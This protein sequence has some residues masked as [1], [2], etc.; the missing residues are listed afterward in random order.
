MK[1][2]LWLFSLIVLTIST[3]K[4]D[5]FSPPTMDR[6]GLLGGAYVALADG[7]EA[8]VWN[9]AGL[10]LP[11]RNYKYELGRPLFSGGPYATIKTVSET[12][13]G[14]GK[15]MGLFPT[16]SSSESTLSI[17]SPSIG[18]ILFKTVGLYLYGYGYRNSLT[19][20]ITPYKGV[21]VWAGSGEVSMGMGFSLSD[22]IF[23]GFSLSY[24]RI[25]WGYSLPL[26]ENLYYND[27][28]LNKNKATNEYYKDPPS[29]GGIRATMGFIY[30]PSDW[31]KIG[32]SMKIPA[33]IS[34]SG[35]AQLYA[36]YEFLEEIGKSYAGDLKF[37]SEVK[38]DFY[39]P[40]WIG[41]GFS[42]S[43]GKLIFSFDLHWTQWSRVKEIKSEF[44]EKTWKEV[45]EPYLEKIKDIPLSWKD[46][47]EICMG[48]KYKIVG[49]RISILLG[50]RFQP[51]QF[52]KGT[53]LPAY[54]PFNDYHIF[55]LGIE[56]ENQKEGYRFSMGFIFYKGKPID[57][58]QSNFGFFQGEYNSSMWMFTGGISSLRLIPY[59]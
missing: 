5:L 2:V 26:K 17:F 51:S 47:T 7:P 36:T 16:F 12:L 58:S 37:E 18:L 31:L 28:F 23:T 24:Q 44:T 38:K 41:G 57:V 56:G 43:K 50:Y 33:K 25:F 4:A 48:I 15:I 22:T 45:L 13:K 21:E 54:F 11:L 39:L 20:K 30:R 40:L 10:A 6:A 53:I 19:P 52:T 42:I 8:V 35:K 49:E 14:K 9:P 34:L 59:F 46:T 55:S 3:L 29:G 32:L 1:R 27:V